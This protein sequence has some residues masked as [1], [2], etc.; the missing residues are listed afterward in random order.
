VDH[1]FANVRNVNMSV[2]LTFEYKYIYF[3]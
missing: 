1:H 2:L 3:F